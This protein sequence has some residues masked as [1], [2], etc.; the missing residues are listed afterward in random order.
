MTEPAST[1]SS[2]IVAKFKQRI[3]ERGYPCVGAKGAVSRSQLTAYV[4]RTIHSAWDDVAL[5]QELGAFGRHYA[6][7][8]PMFTTFVAFFPESGELDERAFE[9]AMWSRI[10]SLQS[11]DDWLGQPPDPN[12]D[13]DPESPMFS[14]SFGG[15]GFFVVGMHPAASRP[16]RQFECPLMVFNLHDQFERLRADGRYE[17]MR[18]TI[19]ERDEELAGSINPMLARFGEE[20]EARQYSG[21]QVGPDWQCPWNGRDAKD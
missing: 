13:G 9:K 2:E 6:Q 7:H 4:G 8:R 15:Q 10:A 11:K 21:R 14:L 12:V 1:R 3:E 18:S 19:L 16:A 17:K 5:A 20:S